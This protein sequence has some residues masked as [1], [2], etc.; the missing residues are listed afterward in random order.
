LH[1]KL[2]PCIITLDLLSAVFFG[3]ISVSATVVYHLG[4]S[5]SIDNF[6]WLCV[7]AI[8]VLAVVTISALALSGVDWHQQATPKANIAR[9][10][11]MII[12]LGGLMVTA[13]TVLNLCNVFFILPM[14]Q[15]GLL[16]T[17]AVTMIGYCVLILSQNACIRPD[18]DTHHDLQ[19]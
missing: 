2:K 9:M 19:H 14:L 8:S 1:N 16:L 3:S 7:I 6:G 17:M 13:I 5:L 11:A 12:K 18:V 15:I 4:F 10:L